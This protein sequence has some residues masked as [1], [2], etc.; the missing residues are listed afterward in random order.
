MATRLLFENTTKRFGAKTALDSLSLAV[1]AGEIFGFL[2]PNGA[3][4]TTALQ[5][6]MGFLRPSSGRGELLGRDFTIARAA[7][8]EVGYVPDAPV[9]FPGTPLE[10]VLLTARL[11]SCGNITDT[12][13][14]AQALLHRLD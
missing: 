2:G 6:A 9:F 11:N 13:S 7:R 8:A 14:R 4:K 1:E 10:A 5:L 3:G 12:R